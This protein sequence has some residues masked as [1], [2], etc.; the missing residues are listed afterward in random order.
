[1]NKKIVLT[2]LI[3]LLSTNLLFAQNKKNRPIGKRKTA[4][5]KNT[6]PIPAPKRFTL[7]VSVEKYLSNIEI[8]VD[9]SSTQT[10]EVLQK[11]NSE[12][13]VANFSKFEQIFNGDLEK[14]EVLET[15]ILKADGKK[16]ALPASA[17][18]IHKTPQAEAAPSFSSLKAVEIKFPDTKIGDT[19][20]YKIKEHNFK[21]QFAGYFDDM[22]IF[23]ALFEWKS[24]E[25]NL[26]APK[27]FPIYSQAIDLEGGKIADENNRA[28]WK[29]SKKDLSAAEI[30]TGTYDYIS[31]SPRLAVTS[32]KDFNELG[33][34][35]WNEAKEK[36]I[37]TPEIQT[38]A[39]EI[40]KDFKEPQQQAYAIYEWVNKNIRYLS[41]VLDR[42]GWIPHHS[43]QILSNGYGDCKDY[44]TILYALLKAKKIESHPVL[45]RAD[46]TDWF[47]DVASA[48]YFNHAILYI[49]SL[50]LFADATA[51]NTRLGLIPQQIVG[52]K[53]FLG[54]EKTGVIQVPAGK[55]ED[56]QIL[57]DIEI[58][59]TADGNLKAVS[60]NVYQ[61]RSEIVFRPLFSD[62]YLQKNSEMFVAAMLGYY[63]IAGTGKI[64][65]IGNPFK[66]GE[67]F[68]IEME[69][70]V[71]DYTTF[72]PKGTLRMPLAVNL[73][74]M[75]SL[76]KFILEEERQTNL[77]LGAT[78]LRERY[79][80]KLPADVKVNQLPANLNF[81]N[82]LGSFRNEF[83]V[84]GNSVLVERELLIKKDFIT[85]Q[86][87]PKIRDLIGKIADAFNTEIPYQANPNLMRRKI[88][89]SRNQ[90]PVKI[91]TVDEIIARQ[92][93]VF[94][95]KPLTAKETAQMEA[96][97]K[98]NPND[99]DSRKRLLRH[100]SK[101]EIAQTP[102]NNAARLRHRIWFVQ[103]QPEYEDLDY[104]LRFDKNE[105]GITN[106][107]KAVKGEWLKQIE[108]DPT[109]AQ[110]RYNAVKFA[111]DAEAEFAEQLLLDGIKLDAE[112]YR[113]QILLSQIYQSQTDEKSPKNP[114]NNRQ[115]LISAFVSGEKA[116]MLLKKERSDE[117]DKDRGV[118]LRTLAQN[119]LKL[120]KLDRAKAFATELILDFGGDASNA[121]FEEA[122]HIG[123]IVLGRVSLR[124]NDLVKAKEHLLIAIRAPLR[125]DKNWL[126]D[127]DTKLA[128]ELFEKGE[129]AIVSEYLN[130]CENLW[131]IKNHPELYEDELKSL[132]LWQEQIKQGKTPS[133][134][135]DADEI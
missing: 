57:S 29:W 74:D 113:F 58:D 20:F 92:F 32:F 128:K 14:F 133:F 110:I 126:S 56:N 46:M 18:S 2:L 28:R 81:T 8:N 27:D 115:K 41:I 62:S 121:D 95:E 9:G 22:E 122:A 63:G 135:F 72:T 6:P 89:Q 105:A 44:T 82:E 43:A 86:E 39:E 35:Y 55:P 12:T 77:V 51:P 5:V 119:A 106:E 118:L 30:E 90:K 21:P 34:A 67:S 120:E 17:I 97:L 83:K 91:Q 23:T 94:D 16:V 87:Y 112:N 37:L 11:L 78:H 47:P 38:L 76:Q 53:A 71:N 109:N 66:V 125:K 3:L 100:Y 84:E 15:Y 36:A 33:A 4:V 114:E 73:M 111:T 75:L 61:G 96:K 131:N 101:Y 124:E 132:K 99:A 68:A 80:L 60:K 93:E 48:S 130:L 117:R 69:V 127:I 31:F 107:Y 108:A 25:V 49:P 52:K 116:L 59:F 104:Y 26:S 70:A 79:K 64:L 45:I 24:I 85:P 10:T 134:D 13:A 1:M 42:G 123:N 19:I 7:G 50:E 102:A 98:Q 65:K 129:K 103:N 40:T 54:G 88:R